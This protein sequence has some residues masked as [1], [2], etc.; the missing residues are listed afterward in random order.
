MLFMFSMLIL[1]NL[2]LLLQ[3]FFSET[4]FVSLSDVP[5]DVSHAAFNTSDST[6]G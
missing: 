1:L 5:D 3:L 2:I 6:N 4:V